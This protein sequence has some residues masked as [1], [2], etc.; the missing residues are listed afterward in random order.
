[1]ATGDSDL[2]ERSGRLVDSQL[3]FDPRVASFYLVVGALLLVLAGGL[4]YRQLIQGE[5]Y[6]S[7]ERQQNQ[8]RIL[9]PGPRGDIYD[10]NGIPL[11]RNRARFAAA[12]LL[13]ELQPEITHEFR[14]IRANYRE[15]GDKD[16]PTYADLEAI[17]RASVVGRYLRQVDSI[18]GR[19][20]PLNNAAL[21]RHFQRQLHLPYVLV[22]DLTPEEFAKA[23]ENLPPSSPVQVYASYVRAYPFGSAAAHVLGYVGA[24]DIID[25]EDF[26]GGDLTTFKMKGA[27]G[28]DGLEK[29]F[30]AQLQGE[31]GGRISR[32]NPDGYEVNPP[33]QKLLPRQGKSLT[34]SLDIGLQL[35][36]EQALGDQTGAAVALDVRTGEVLAMA[37]KPDYDLNSFSPRLSQATVD[38][39]QKRGA[40]Y[41]LAIAGLYPPGSTFKTVVSVAGLRSGRIDPE[42]FTVDCEGTMQI[43]NRVFGCDN[44]RGHH[45]ELTLVPA[46]AESCDIYFWT[47]GLAIGPE[48]IAAEARR[49][50]LDRPTGI[51]LPGEIKAMIVPDAAWKRKNRDEA[52]TD[53]D[54]ANFAI[55]QGFLRVTPL[56]MAC[57][58]ASLARGE[59]TT[60]PTLVHD[61][62]R[63]EQHTEPLGLTPAQRAA[64]IAGMVACTDTTYPDDTASLLSTVAAFRIP[65]VRIAGKTGTA[66]VTALH[67]DVAWFICFAPADDPKI[68]VA[69]TVQGDVGHEDFGGAL[70][71]AP[72]ADAILQAYFR[73]HPAAGSG[74]APAAVT[75]GSPA[76]GRTAG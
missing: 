62:N 37:S 70:H 51:E 39:I 30:D 8:R 7:R 48:R 64:L 4:A 25:A 28:R 13:D 3:G 19:D 43:G 17:A 2:A 27:V 68:A 42:K 29:S 55:G 16:L 11:V 49:F 69:A 54:T 20:E 31:A 21:T 47:A 24:D 6:Q 45:G 10:R 26:P 40:W 12:L 44:G 63:P 14:R 59:A 76:A 60:V 15:T 75:T 36:A 52:W 32:V 58:A 9:L 57:W 50:G 67:T 38:D 66:Q 23:V 61:P 18:V 34:T 71:C 35:A 46:I 1:M 33:L 53:G 22:D 73:K 65:G 5:I 41:N 74:P 72:V 56:Q